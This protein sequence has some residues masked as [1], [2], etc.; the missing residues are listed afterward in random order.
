MFFNVCLLFVRY[1]QR[2]CFD[3]LWGSHTNVGARIWWWE[4]KGAEESEKAAEEKQGELSGKTFN[5]INFQVGTVSITNNP[6][7]L[8]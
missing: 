7:L 6:R 1:G 5:I 4:R 2:R 3:L 8:G